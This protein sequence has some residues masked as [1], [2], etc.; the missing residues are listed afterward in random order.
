MHLPKFIR[1]FLARSTS[2]PVCRFSEPPGW[3]FETQSG[4]GYVQVVLRGNDGGLI[5]QQTL[6]VRRLQNI[7]DSA[8]TSLK[9]ADEF[10]PVILPMVPTRTARPKLSLV[11]HQHQHQ[12]EHDQ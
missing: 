7:L 1:R 3:S 9:V 10:A 4:S 8:S 12:Q 11:Q 2:N 6:T 5:H